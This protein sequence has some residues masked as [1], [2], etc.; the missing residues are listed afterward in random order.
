LAYLGIEAAD[1]DAWQRFGD[2][3]GFD[4]AREDGALVFRM[5]E[6]ARRIVVSNGPRDDLCFLGW[7][8]ES[9]GDLD[10]HVRRLQDGGVAVRNGAAE[11]AQLRAVERFVRFRDPCETPMEL[12]IG[13]RL[14]GSAFSSLHLKYGFLTGSLGLGH[15]LI[16]AGDYLKGERFCRDFLDGVVSDH[17][18]MPVPTGTF[19]ASFLHMNK[20]HHSIAYVQSPMPRTKRIHHFM[21][22]CN[23]IEDV[24]R[25]Y[26]RLKSVGT[27]FAMTLGQH[28]NDKQISFYAQTPSGFFMELGAGGVQVDDATWVP[29]TH[30]AI[31]LWGHERPPLR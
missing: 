16:P 22:E 31:S 4:A 9:A 29:T 1:L 21:V 11:E 17:I 28:T 27:R 26:D 13:A 24:G 20:R 6:R 7:E 15:V 18:I 12:A 14:A 10:L 5:D 19:A 8:V 25:A 30:A 2:L 3:V 23:E